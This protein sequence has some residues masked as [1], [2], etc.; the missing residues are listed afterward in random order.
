MTTA[1]SGNVLLQLLRKGT[2]ITQD[3]LGR[4]DV[5]P[6][7]SGGALPTGTASAPHLGFGGGQI[8]P[9]GCRHSKPRAVRDTRTLCL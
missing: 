2:M 6:A 7:G 1:S 4:Q 3:G 9:K 8:G 5:V